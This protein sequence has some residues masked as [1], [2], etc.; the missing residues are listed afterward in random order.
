MS[1]VYIAV[2]LFRRQYK[3]CNRDF[4]YQTTQED[5]EILRNITMA[6]DRDDAVIKT[7]ARHVSTI[8]NM[9]WKELGELILRV[10]PINLDESQAFY[11][12]FDNR[13]L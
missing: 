5:F 13:F 10:T 8:E 6:T 11:Q 2:L 12:V 9:R 3:T 1:H 4:T 7:L